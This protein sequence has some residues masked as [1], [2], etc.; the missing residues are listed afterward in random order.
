MYITQ[1][2]ET[3]Q[4]RIKSEVI[5]ALKDLGLDGEEFDEALENAMD[6]KLADLEDLI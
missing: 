3:E 4:K 6:S 2:E 1:L 5:E